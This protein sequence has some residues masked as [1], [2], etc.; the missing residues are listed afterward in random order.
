VIIDES[1]PITPES[2]YFVYDET[3]EVVF[4]LAYPGCRPLGRIDRRL[5][6][7]EEMQLLFFEH[8][9][10]ICR[11]ERHMTEIKILKGDMDRPMMLLPQEVSV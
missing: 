1:K 6:Q 4:A 5:L 2:I 10:G 11:G 7:N 9:I 8:L 3:K